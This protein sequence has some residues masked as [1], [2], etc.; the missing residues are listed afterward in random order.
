MSF[1]I[2]SDVTKEQL[3]DRKNCDTFLG[4]ELEIRQK[5]LE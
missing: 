4:R 3:Q 2:K 5:K 1:L